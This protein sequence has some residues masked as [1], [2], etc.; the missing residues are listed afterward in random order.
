MREA[1]QIEGQTL[2]FKVIKLD[3]KR[4]NVVL[5][6]RA[7][8]EA[9]TSEARKKLAETLVEGSVVSGVVKNLTDYGAFVD[10]GGI[11]GLLHITDMAWRRVRH[12]SD[13]L[14]PGQQINAKI[15]KYDAEKNRVSL[16]LKQL[17]SDP[18]EGLARRLPK[19]SRLFGKISNVADYGVF[20]EIEEGV[21]GLVHASEMEWSTKTPSPS[22]I[23]HAGQEV[24]VMVLEVDEARRRVSLGMKQCKPNPWE[25]FAANRRR[26][27]TVRG[28]IK[29]VTDFGVFVGVDGVDALIHLADLSASEPGEE[30]MKKLKKGDSIEA[31]ILS[32][33]TERERVSLGVKQIG[34]AEFSKPARSASSERDEAPPATA[35]G[36]LLKSAVG[37]KR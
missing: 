30:A 22:K 33:D 36:N 17:G 15:L 28:V 8:M 14:A 4:N 9:S 26:G 7:L 32:I 3:R 34:S 1:P 21:E 24:E 19:G 23:A 20:V 25:D 2:E 6:R 18:W 10:L 37:P 5:S 31:V 12:P 29:S 27:E 13:M 16:G 11:D 35:F